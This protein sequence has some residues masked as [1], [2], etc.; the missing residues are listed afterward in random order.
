MENY[1]H[2]YYYDEVL[3]QR[4][5]TVCKSSDM[6]Q[7]ARYTLKPIEQKAIIYA[8]SKIKPNDTINTEYEF[9]IKDFLSVCG[10]SDKNYSYFKKIIKELS[11]RSWWFL[12]EDNKTEY[13]VRWFNTLKIE[14]G[15]GTV[16]FKFHEEMMPFLMD[17]MNEEI[18]I[19]KYKLNYIL[20]MNSTYS[21]RLYEILKSLSNRTSWFFEID[22]LKRLLDCQKYKN[23]NDFNK[24]VL[25]P[26]M[27]EINKY[28]DIACICNPIRKGKKVIRVV[29]HFTFKT[30]T[31]RKELHGIIRDELDGQMIM[32]ELQDTYITE[33]L[34]VI[35]FWQERQRAEELDAE[36]H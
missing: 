26:A 11:D 23:F 25:T 20:P 14:R 34:D 12:T 29:F 24:R 32:E 8:I 17:L 27:T 1:E 22:D 31:E 2:G 9:E 35:C 5:Q 30:E 15:S 10:V 19:T 4:D 3:K 6:I 13:L 7:R 16:K 18:F 33:N 21:I 28:T 36:N